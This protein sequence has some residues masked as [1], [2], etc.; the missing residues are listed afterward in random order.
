M[1]LLVYL[2]SFTPSVT[3]KKS[4]IK[5]TVL[6]IN[7]VHPIVCHLHLWLFCMDNKIAEKKVFHHKHWLFQSQTHQLTVQCVYDAHLIG[8][9]G[10]MSTASSSDRFFFGVLSTCDLNAGEDK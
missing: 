7:L 10:G 2:Y 9:W 3:K 1:N 8:V 4:L 5:A 6:F